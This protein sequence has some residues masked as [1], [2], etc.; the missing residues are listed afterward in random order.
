[1]V[2]QASRPA[3]VGDLHEA[4]KASR[5]IL[6]VPDNAGEIGFDALVMA[7]LKAMGKHVALVV[8]EGSFFEDATMEDARFF[9]LEGL[10]DE[11]VTTRGFLAPADL[12]PDAARALGEADLIM[13]KGTGTYEALHG[14]PLG[15]PVVFMLKVKCPALARETGM[16]MGTVVVKVEQPKG[17]KR[18]QKVKVEVEV[19]KK[20]K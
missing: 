7:Q 18:Q 10:V 20:K 2:E 14:E 17:R 8:K 4:V 3:I 15:K 5:T 9:G 19:E 1:M 12:E 13:A 11:I 6:Y 16:G